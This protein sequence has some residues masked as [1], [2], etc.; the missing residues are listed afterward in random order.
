ML[1]S[2]WLGCE[3]KNQD[4]WG[5]E[6]PES[7]KLPEAPDATIKGNSTARLLGGLGEGTWGRSEASVSLSK[8]R[9]NMGQVS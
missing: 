8:E 4:Q 7:R 6:V 2:T 1:I 3:Q 9:M 5:E